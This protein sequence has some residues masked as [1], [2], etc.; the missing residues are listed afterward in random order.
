MDKRLSAL[1]SAMSKLEAEGYSR[2]VAEGVP[3]GYCITHLGDYFY[4]ISH[5]GS[6]SGPLTSVKQAKGWIAHSVE[7]SSELAP[8]VGELWNYA[9]RT[10]IICGNSVS[11]NG[12]IWVMDWNSG[13]R[14]DANKNMLEVR[15]DRKSLNENDIVDRFSQWAR[16][17]NPDAMWWL[18]WWFEGK[19]HH[20]SVW[21]YVAAMRSDPEGLG[22]A[23]ERVMSDARS[24]HMCEGV[25]DPDTSFVS[26]IPELRGAPIGPDWLSAVNEAEKAVHVPAKTQALNRRV[27]RRSYSAPAK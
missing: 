14:A 20:R 17:G 12:T 11:R 26:S 23:Q 16:D 18:A 24:A 21:Y 9:G 2:V 1:E 15:A 8:R 27:V 10:A 5:D 3:K 4:G 7:S 25:P 13:A 22:W 19:N 6:R